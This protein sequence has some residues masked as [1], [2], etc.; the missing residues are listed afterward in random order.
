MHIAKDVSKLILFLLVLVGCSKPPSDSILGPLTVEHPNSKFATWETRPLPI[1]GLAFSARVCAFTDGQRP[2]KAQL[3][4]M[5][6]ALTV[7]QDM[8]QKMEEEMLPEYNDWRSASADEA[9]NSDL[10]KIFKASD[11]WGAYSE[12]TINVDEDPSSISYSFRLKADPGHEMIVYLK[13]G[14]LD[15]VMIEG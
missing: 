12:L 9:G 6:K 11:I 13:N 1:K 4:A 14:L 7:S 8:K 10:P 15:H 5:V 3:E 2:S